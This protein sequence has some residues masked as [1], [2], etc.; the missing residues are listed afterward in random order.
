MAFAQ[1]GENKAEAF[2]GPRPGIGLAFRGQGGLR[3]DVWS[4]GFDASGGLLVTEEISGIQR[5]EREKARDNGSWTVCSH[6]TLV[7]V[8]P[9][10]LM[11]TPRGSVTLL[12]LEAEAWTVPLRT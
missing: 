2:L 6:Y 3:M 10:L 9:S 1:G 4:E 7:A 11:K 12:D 5:D 8:G